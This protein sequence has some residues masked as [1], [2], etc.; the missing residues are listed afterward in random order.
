MTAPAMIVDDHTLQLTAFKERTLILR[1][2]RAAFHV[3]YA[4]GRL[5][6]TKVLVEQ[7]GKV[8]AAFEVPW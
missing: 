5:L 8:I 1:P 4:F 6:K 2:T 7:G 3:A